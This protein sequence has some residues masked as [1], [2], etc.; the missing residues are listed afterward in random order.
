MPSENEISRM[1][2]TFINLIKK[3]T[4]LDKHQFTWVWKHTPW[5]LLIA[6]VQ[7]LVPLHIH[8]KPRQKFSAAQYNANGRCLYKKHT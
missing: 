7:I 1:T 5:E 4:W 2:I 6:N 3:L 8:T